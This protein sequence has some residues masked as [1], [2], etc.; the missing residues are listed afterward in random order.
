MNFLFYFLPVFTA[1]RFVSIVFFYE[2]KSVFLKNFFRGI[3]DGL[4]GNLGGENE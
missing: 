2:N 1:K 3:I 4:K